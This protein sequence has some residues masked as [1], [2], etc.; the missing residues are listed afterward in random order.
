MEKRGEPVN[1]TNSRRPGSNDV[2]DSNQNLSWVPPERLLSMEHLSLTV[3]QVMKEL[4]AGI[5]P[6]S[7][8]LT[9]HMRRP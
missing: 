5:M 2:S 3:G 7:A 1:T 4:R 8:T 9:T 6:S